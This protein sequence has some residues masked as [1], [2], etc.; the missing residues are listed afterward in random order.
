MTSNGLPFDVRSTTA[1]RP[2]GSDVFVLIHG[3]GTSHR[4]LTRLHAELSAEAD[5]HSIDLPG[6][7]GV[8]KPG[9]SPDIHTMATALAA[10]LD[11]LGVE[12]AVVVGH[13]MGAQ[14]TVELGVLRPDL[15]AHL[16]LIGP[17]TDDTHRSLP[18]QMFTLTRDVLGEPPFVNLTVFADYLR[19][20]PRW[21]L[22]QSRFMIPYPIEDRLRRLGMTVL[23]LRGGNDPIAT[24]E[25]CR[26]LVR[27]AVR[28]RLV[29][30]PG[31][32][33]VVQ[34]TAPRSVAS[35]IRFFLTD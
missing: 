32:R 23:V 8:P 34:F 29:V 18:Y 10:L 16:V 24:T 14:W 11:Q 17:V 13:S 2:L 19:C 12:H 33:H 20:G 7:G 28:G 3:I 31:H 26:R 4:Y 1:P 9:S 35:A 6:F 30:V 27:R 5:V 22:N 21:F 25:W 15:V